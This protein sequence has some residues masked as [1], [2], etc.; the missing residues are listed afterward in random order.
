MASK[1]NFYSPT[2]MYTVR[3]I[4]EARKYMKI[5]D[6]CQGIGITLCESY[7]KYPVVSQT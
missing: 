5:V 3:V 7:I 1:D 6:K 2:R 4:Q